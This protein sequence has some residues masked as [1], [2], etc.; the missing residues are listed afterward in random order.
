MKLFACK[1]YI[2]LTSLGCPDLLD[3]DE[4]GLDPPAPGGLWNSL[5]MMPCSFRALSISDSRIS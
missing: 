1:R 3:M 2:S 5:P 4:L